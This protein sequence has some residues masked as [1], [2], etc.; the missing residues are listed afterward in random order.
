MSTNSRTNKRVPQR[1]CIACRQVK[2]KQELIRL[3]RTSDNSIE[4]D[5]SGKRSGRG[6]YLCKSRECWETGL[7]ENRLEHNLRTTLAPDD[8]E[9][10]IKYGQDNY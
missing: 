5:I 8:R 4:V 10:L 3:I 2:D 9:R 1:T 6:A 7:N